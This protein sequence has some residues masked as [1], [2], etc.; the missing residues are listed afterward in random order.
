MNTEERKRRRQTSGFTIVELMIVVGILAILTSVAIPAFSRYVKKSRTAEAS[1]HL[2]KMWAGSVAYFES[3]HADSNGVL[4]PKQFPGPSAPQEAN[5]CSA[6]G[7]KCPGSPSTYDNAVWVA[8]QLNIPDPHNF[9][10]VYDATGTGTA[11]LFT[12]RANGDL[13]CDSTLSTFQRLGHVNTSSGD[14]ESSGPAF[15]DRPIE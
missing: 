11:A 3:D 15:I 6:P 5:C 9:R 2:N 8:L 14:V 13:D 12:A 10:P 1:Y 4:N 7:E